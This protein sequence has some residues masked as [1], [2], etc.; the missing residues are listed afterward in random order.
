VIPITSGSLDERYAS[1]SSMSTGFHKLAYLKDD[2]A[3]RFV[4]FAPY[5][6]DDARLAIEVQR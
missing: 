1:A 6:V 4:A 5:Q 3:S 2:V